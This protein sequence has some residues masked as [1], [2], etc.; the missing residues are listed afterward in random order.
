MKTAVNQ[1]KLGLAVITLVYRQRNLLVGWRYLMSIVHLHTYFKL[2][3]M[4]FMD[5]VL[6]SVN[7]FL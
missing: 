3:I 5:L 4:Y 1:P 2:T 7:A 6:F